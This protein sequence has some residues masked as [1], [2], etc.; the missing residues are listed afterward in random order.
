MCDELDDEI[1]LLTA[2]YS[3][4]ELTV[5]R[6]GAGAKISAKLLPFTAGNTH[7]QLSCCELHAHIGEAY[8][9]VAPCIELGSSRGLSDAAHSLILARLQASAEEYIGQPMISMLLESGRDLLTEVNGCDSECSICLTA[10]QEDISMQVVRLPCFHAF[11]RSCLIDYCRSELDR[12]LSLMSPESVAEVNI[13]CPECRGEI[14]W[15]SFAELER[16]EQTLIESKAPRKGYAVETPG[17]AAELILA[18]R[19]QR[20]VEKQCTSEE[21]S[22]N[23]PE[24]FVR[25][26]HLWQGNDEK[27]KPLLRLLKELDLSARVYYG[28]PALM[29][30]QGSQKDVDLFAGT[31]KRRR[32]TI[33]IDVVQRSS[34]PCIPRGISSIAAKKGSL[35]SSTLAEHLQQRGLGESSFTIIGT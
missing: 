24:A 27:E 1:E 34:G 21:S 32:I 20:S 12:K 18:D 6:I 33:T 26:H 4:D 11:H 31:A 14:Q 7:M 16:A 23:M 9:Q 25:L 3:E 35:D 19:E 28:K 17:T 10:I 5:E 13:L 30:I 2:M 15:Q 29:H 8:P 22:S